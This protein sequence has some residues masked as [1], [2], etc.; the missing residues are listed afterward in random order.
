MTFYF[1]NYLFNT[2]HEKV[3]VFNYFFLITMCQTHLIK[4]NLSLQK[5]YA[6]V[7]WKT[8]NGGYNHYICLSLPVFSQFLAGN[9]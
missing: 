2:G 3:Y 9:E 1:H 4:E 8:S 7:F 6:L 5:N